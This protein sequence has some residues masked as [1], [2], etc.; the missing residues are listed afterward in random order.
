MITGRAPGVQDYFDD[1][2]LFFFELGEA[3]DLARCIV[4]VFSH[5]DAVARV[6]KRG[7]DVYVAHRWSEE[8]RRLVTRSAALLPR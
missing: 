3:E 2:A 5:P 7:Q 8:R 6:V 4:D 1:D